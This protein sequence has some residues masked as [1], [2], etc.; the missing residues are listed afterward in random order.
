MLFAAR[1]AF[2]R[3]TGGN[4]QSYQPPEHPDQRPGGN[5]RGQKIGVIVGKNIGLQRRG[6]LQQRAGLDVQQGTVA[7]LALVQLAVLLQALGN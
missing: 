7:D 6:V 2:Q 5:R 1:R 3:D 4:T